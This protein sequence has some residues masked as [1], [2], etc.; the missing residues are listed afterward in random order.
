M[1]SAFFPDSSSLTAATYQPD[2]ARLRIIFRD[3][4]C[5]EY[6][7]VPSIVFSSLVNAGSKGAFFNASI[8][9]VF[10]ARSGSAMSI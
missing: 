2:S 8:R 7:D 6:F 3:R 9:N 5:Y 1:I 4:S 10:T